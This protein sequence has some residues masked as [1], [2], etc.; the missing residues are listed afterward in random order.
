MLTISRAKLS[1]HLRCI[2]ALTKPHIVICTDAP[3]GSKSPNK[4]K[5]FCDCDCDCD[6]ATKP[7]NSDDGHDHVASDSND[8]QPKSAL[9]RISYGCSIASMWFTYKSR[10]YRTVG[11]CY[12]F[13]DKQ[14]CATPLRSFDHGCSAGRHCRCAWR[15]R[16][17]RPYTQ[18]TCER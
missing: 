13:S 17:R 18:N 3:F 2:A 5:L 1:L 9:L 4:P 11:E 16:S 10:I 8:A 12:F 14:L 6:C 15:A 7:R